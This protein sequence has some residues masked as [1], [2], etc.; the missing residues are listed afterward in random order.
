MAKYAQM[1]TFKFKLPCL[2]IKVNI[3]EW[4]CVK[5]DPNYFTQKQQSHN[6]DIGAHQPMALQS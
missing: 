4:L 2:L 6:D 1:G 5:S 3:H